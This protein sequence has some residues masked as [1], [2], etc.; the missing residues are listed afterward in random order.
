MSLAFPLL[1][2]H[3][4]PQMLSLLKNISYLDL[5]HT[6]KN[7]T[8]MK[9]I[10]SDINR[11]IVSYPGCLNRLVNWIPFLVAV[12][13]PEKSECEKFLNSIGVSCNGNVEK[14]FDNVLLKKQILKDMEEIG[15][16]NDLK[17]F[18]MVKQIY[19]TSE[20][21]T[22]ENNLLTPTLKIK[23]NEVRKKYAKEI[24]EM[25]RII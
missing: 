22:I 4:Y 11:D 23:S 21:F 12:V 15:K 18:E 24:A 19:I 3:Q 5:H 13:V 16:K 17:G 7:D 20:P 25:Y 8:M 14:Y 2:S 6:L 9:Y 10:F 1:H